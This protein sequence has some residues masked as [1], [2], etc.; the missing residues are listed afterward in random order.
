MCGAEGRRGAAPASWTFPPLQGISKHLGFETRQP[1]YA[2]L[3]RFLMLVTAGSAERRSF[4]L[5]SPV[6][7]KSNA[8]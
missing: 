5:R 3:L 6:K 1:D 2:P 4:P 7:D 8:G